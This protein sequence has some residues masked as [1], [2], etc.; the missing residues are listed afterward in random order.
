[1]QTY[2]VVTL[3]V[4]GFFLGKLDTG[5]LKKIR[6]YFGSPIRQQIEFQWGMRQF[7]RIFSVT[8]SERFYDAS[9]LCYQNAFV[10]ILCGFGFIDIVRYEYTTEHDD[11]VAYKVK[12]YHGFRSYRSLLKMA[13]DNM[14]FVQ[15]ETDGAT[16]FYQL[17]ICGH[18]VVSD[19][20]SGE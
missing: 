3:I 11:R 15:K 8:G 19:Y 18:N 9:A 5:T 20:W 13:K 7:F 1:M 4:I 14:Q 10:S 17:F 2:E 6:K 16:G 12:Y